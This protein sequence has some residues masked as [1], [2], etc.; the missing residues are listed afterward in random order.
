[1]ELAKDI[2][3][4]NLDR[5]KNKQSLEHV[6]IDPNI[7][8]REYQLEAI[9]SV[10]ETFEEGHRKALLVMATGTGH[11]YT[12][13]QIVYRLLKSGMKERVLYLADRNDMKFSQKNF[14]KK[15]HDNPELKELFENEVLDVLTS[16]IPDLEEVSWE[17]D[18]GY[19]LTQSVLGKLNN[20]CIPN[21]S[22]T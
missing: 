10:C 14:K 1:M 21:S 4:S 17:E 22:A 9:K 18:Y 2:S 20:M 16:L 5:R 13:F 12:A 8:G 3:C 7:A 15:M 19:A 6:Y 11:T